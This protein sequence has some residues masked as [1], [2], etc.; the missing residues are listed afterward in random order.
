MERPRFFAGQT[1]TEAELNADQRYVLAKSRLHNRYLHGTGI[2]CGLEVAC[3]DAEGVVLVRPGYALDACGNDLVVC[4]EQRLDIASLIARCRDVDG[5]RRGADCDPLRPGAGR[6]GQP[7][8][9]WCLT[10][11]YSERE[12]RARTVLRTDGRGACGCGGS[13]GCGHNGNGNLKGRGN[14]CGCD[15]A[16]AAGASGASYRQAS[17]SAGSLATTTMG[18]CEPTRIVETVNFD[19]CQ[20]PP[21]PCR[22]PA[23]EL[24]DSL[25]WSVAACYAEYRDF[26]GARIPRTYFQP[27]VAAVFTREAVTDAQQ[28]Y[29]AYCYLRQALYELDSRQPL[30]VSCALADTL[31]RIKLAPP[32]A[33]DGDTETYR[34]QAQAAL[35]QLLAVLFQSFVD[36]VCGA[37]QP[38]CPPDP[39]DER[40]VLACMGVA[41]GRIVR[42]CNACRHYAGAFP[43]I[44]HWLSLVPVGPLLGAAVEWL[45]C[46]P[47][48]EGDRRGNR[49]FELLDGIDPTY[50]RA[51]LHQEDF[52]Q[53]RRFLQGIGHLPGNLSAQRVGAILMDPTRAG[54]VLRAALR[55]DT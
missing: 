51:R 22:D 39:P 8:E 21:G 28:L 34:Q 11:A 16:T 48:T 7:Q 26:L 36:C 33:G 15:H 20:A 53:I 19:V 47:W 49:L 23:T 45:C 18:A 54:E 2:V 17:F 43:S 25:L 42:I 24:Q 30:P 14:R 10:I 40:L 1:L 52:A 4:D 13:C 27:I 32:P 46:Q 44:G 12:A 41:D 6:N 3:G 5:R 9:R 29:D 31:D 37:L 38:P 35:Q 55:P 50:R